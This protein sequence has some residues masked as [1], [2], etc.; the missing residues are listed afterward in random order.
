LRRL[1]IALCLSENPKKLP[2][3][4]IMNRRN[5]ALGKHCARHGPA[6]N[7]AGNFNS[8]R[9]R[10]N[11]PYQH[12]G[13]TGENYRAR[14]AA[15]IWP[16]IIELGCQLMKQDANERLIVAAQRSGIWT[17]HLCWTSDCERS[18]ANATISRYA[19][20]IKPAIWLTGF[21]TRP[22]GKPAKRQPAFCAKTA[23]PSPQHIATEPDGV[24]SHH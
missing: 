14:I 1:K 18:P 10:A 22:S 20:A 21:I 3:E 6:R 24:F 12:T 2:Q 15:G 4:R 23:A 11:Q 13:N 19:H 8:N 16:V 9:H 17:N 7:V 5:I